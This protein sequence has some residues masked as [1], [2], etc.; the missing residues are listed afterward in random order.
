M[1]NLLHDFYKVIGFKDI[2]PSIKKVMLY[3]MRISFIIVLLATLL[4][5]IYMDFYSS[6][7]LFA[8]ASTLFKSGT[9]FIA[10]FF[11]Y[12]ICFNKMSGDLSK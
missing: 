12:G 9:M 4:L 7:Y 8:I 11:I 10:I 5:C 6:N 1:K 2:L 3:G